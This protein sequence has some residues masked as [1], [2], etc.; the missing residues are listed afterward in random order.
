MI[1]DATDKRALAQE[2]LSS[3]EATLAKMRASAEEARMGAIHEESRPENDKD[4]RGLEASYLARGQAERVAALVDE[5]ERVRRMP[6]PE[7]RESSPIALGA[8]VSL[9]RDD[10][11]ARTVFLSPAGGG[12]RLGGALEVQVVT[13]STPLGRALLGKHQG[14]E[15]ELQVGGATRSFLVTGLA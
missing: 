11:A 12:I 10:G 13:P 3:L 6:I 14:D 9:E 8:L 7:L 15:L 2:L 5:V 1:L 4:T